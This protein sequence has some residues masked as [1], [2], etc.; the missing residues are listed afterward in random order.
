MLGC[1][2]RLCNDLAMG[3]IARIPRL[4]ML[5]AQGTVA[6]DDGFEA[7][8]RS[9]TLE[10][11][12]GR[13]CPNL[14]GRGFLSLSKLP[15]LRGLAVS[16]R[17]VDAEALAALPRFPALRELMPMDVTDAGFRHVG[18]CSKL[19]GLWCMYCRETTDAATEHLAGLTELKTYY[20]G[21]T[22]IT[23]RSL[24]LLGR[25]PSL[26]VVEFY[27]CK[28]LTNAG[29]VFLARL[30]RLREISLSGLPYVTLEG[31]KVFPANVRVKHSV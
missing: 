17:N 15:A 10:Y 20:A 22:K 19:E 1:E 14:T 21:L 8:S 9:L 31:T 23:D 24:E 27:E 3:Y 25:L 4:R 28:N 2:G 13:E 5:M 29:L 26:E 6:T 18:S 16:C 7:L 30:P 11:I 12:W